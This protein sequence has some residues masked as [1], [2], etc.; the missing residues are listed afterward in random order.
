[1]CVK[2]FLLTKYSKGITSTPV[3]RF[4]LMFQNGVLG[5]GGH[6]PLQPNAYTEGLPGRSTRIGRS[7]PAFKWR[8]GLFYR[9]CVSEMDLYSVT[10]KEE[11]SAV[12]GRRPNLPRPGVRLFARRKRK[13]GKGER[14]GRMTEVGCGDGVHPPSPSVSGPREEQPSRPVLGTQNRTRKTGDNTERQRTLG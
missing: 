13:K 12:V 1:M 7:T 2:S 14:N 3:L 4:K 10:G 6:H 8:Y 9:F 5:I 11:R